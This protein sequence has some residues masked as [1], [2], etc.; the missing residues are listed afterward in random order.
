[1]KVTLE[2]IIIAGMSFGNPVYR[3]HPK[4]APYTYKVHNGKHVIDLV[5]SRQQL[6]QAR[7]F[8]A[9]MRREGNDI[10]FVGTRHQLGPI[11]KERA[12]TVKRFFVSERWLGGILTNRSTIQRSLLKLH[13]LEYEQKEGAWSSLQKKELIL[14]KKRLRRLQRYLGGLKGIRKLPG[15]VIIVGQTKELTSI[16]ECR[17]LGIPIVCRLDTDC[18]PSLVEVGVPINDDSV[19]RV[20]LFL[21]AM[22]PRIEEGNNWF[23]LKNRKT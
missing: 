18:D 13:Q 5:K 7:K 8:V 6:I 4:I 1:M 22:L 10:L 15:V 23:R 16:Y 14:L 20:S 19:A 12:Q 3:W 11:I 17:K 21:K 2:Q 9:K